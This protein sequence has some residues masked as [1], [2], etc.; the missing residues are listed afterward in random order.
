[1]SGLSCD[2]IEKN[3][4]KP[5]ISQVRENGYLDLSVG[6]VYSLSKCS[7]KQDIKALELAEGGVILVITLYNESGCALRSSLAALAENVGYILERKPQERIRICLIADGA[8]FISPSV[9]NVFEALGFFLSSMDDCNDDLVVYRRNI[10]LAKL[11]EIVEQDSLLHQEPGDEHWLNIHQ[12]CETYNRRHNLGSHKSQSVSDGELELLVCVK[13]ANSGKLDSHWWY[14][15]VLCTQISPDYCFQ[16]DVGTAPLTDALFNICEAFDKNPNIGALA[17]SVYTP[18]PKNNYDILQ[19]WQYGGF[20]KAML[21]DWPGE[22]ASGYLS[23]IPGQF[24]GVRWDA[25]KFDERKSE[26]AQVLDVYFKGLGELAPYEST[27]YLAEDRVLC[28]E[29]VT[30]E[31]SAWRLDYVDSALAV[32]DACHSWGELLKQ[33]KRWCNGYLSC[34]LNFISKVPRYLKSPGQGLSS[35]A[36]MLSAA[37]YHSLLTMLDW[38][39]PAL[40]VFCYIELAGNALSFLAAGSVAYQYMLILSGMTFTGLLLQAIMLFRGELDKRTYAAMFF[41][42][43][44]QIVFTL[45]SAA[46]FL[47]SGASWINMSLLAVIFLSTP[48]AALCIGKVKLISVLKYQLQYMLINPAIELLLWTYAIFNSHDNSWGTKGLDKPEY[49]QVG[50]ESQQKNKVVSQYKNFRMAYSIGWLLS[51]AL[52]VLGLYF[53]STATGFS[54]ITL[55]LSVLA[56][57]AAFSTIPS[58]L[59][60]LIKEKKSLVKRAVKKQ[61]K[62]SVTLKSQSIRV[63]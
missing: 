51:N 11:A 33:R 36:T 14:Y 35:K 47:R 63:D 26:G 22:V 55:V 3:S 53:L 42:V 50:E 1:V 59:K 31:D 6:S 61:Q 13:H 8:E 58:I 39:L 52:L 10:K 45:T 18:E 49:Q 25:I 19:L 40:L 56:F 46:V 34:R 5:H 27:L 30:Q 21:R 41:S 48:I 28:S 38:F 32:T 54:G 29:I 62:N 43:C 60:V 20:A 16:M 23:V 57:N 44:C 15:Q 37:A 9:V 17:S 4:V 12:E 7:Y 2:T 24:S